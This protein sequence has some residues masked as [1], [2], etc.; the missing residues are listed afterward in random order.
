MAN[1]HQGYRTND[2]HNPDH[3]RNKFKKEDVVENTSAAV[4]QVI[5]N[6]PHDPDHPMNKESAVEV[7]ETSVVSSS[8]TVLNDPHD[9]N[10][11]S[12]A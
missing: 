7:T 5:Y 2:P 6:D 10:H 9:P 11:P 12:N 3:P 8:H 1:K 4:D